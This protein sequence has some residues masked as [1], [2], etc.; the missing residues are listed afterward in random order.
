MKMTL[1]QVAKYAQVSRG[2]V[3]RVVN[4]RGN[5][6]PA[7]RERVE[8]ALKDLNYQPN[9]IA[10]ALAY[11]KYEKKVC[12]IFQKYEVLSSDQKVA[13]GIRDA[14]N[15]LKDFG[16]SVETVICDDMNS[17]KFVEKIDE[18]VADGMNGFVVRGP[19]VPEMI[20]KIN[21]LKRYGIPVVTF[22]SDIPKS[23]RVCFIGQD[24]YQ[25]GR[26]AGNIMA[27]LIRPGEK[28]IISCGVPQY[29]AHH[30]RVD[31]FV[32]ELKRRGVEEE[33][34]I[35]LR[36]EAKYDVMY[37]QFKRIFS[38]EENI[39]GIYISV[40]PNAAC[41]D[42]LRSERLDTYPYVICHDAT[43]ESISYLKEGFFDFI[44]DQNMYMQSYR[45][46]LILKDIL[47]NQKINQ[48]VASDIKIYNAACFE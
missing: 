21:D 10:S 19:D 34:W 26:I 17:K 41:R 40:E 47:L 24:L 22:N 33:Q 37:E 1:E 44:I 20:E 42:Y 9:K 48:E 38:E 15:E 3:D 6:K 2:T 28:I 7:V 30:K 23:Q 45:A 43:V 12:I 39:R 14:Q 8:Q 31:G 11:S 36:A 16:I 25:S 5:V 32:Y 29:D 18:M 35:I 13:E 46:L 27:K 4:R